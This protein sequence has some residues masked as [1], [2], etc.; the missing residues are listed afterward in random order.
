MVPVDTLANAAA[1]GSVIL[2]VTMAFLAQL[3]AVSPALSWWATALLFNGIGLLLQG[4]LPADA[5]PFA[6]L[7]DGAPFGASALLVYIGS[8]R[9]YAERLEFGPVAIGFAALGLLLLLSTILAL[10]LV[11]ILIGGALFGAAHRFWRDYRGTRDPAV[12]CAVPPIALSGA[13]ALVALVPHQYLPIGQATLGTVMQLANVAAAM[14]LTAVA[15]RRG[16]QSAIETELQR[17]LDSLQLHEREERLRIAI[18]AERTRLLEV[19]EGVPQGLVLYDDEDRLAFCNTSYNRMFPRTRDLNNPGATFEELARASAERG[20]YGKDPAA[21]AATLERR[22]AQHRNPGEPGQ[23]E[24]DDGSIIQVVEHRAHDGSTVC[25]YSDITEFRRREN[26]LTLIVS[27]QPGARSFLDAAAQAL[28]VGL[29]YRWAGIAERLPDGKH[30]RT[31]AAWDSGKPGAPITYG[32]ADTPCEVVYRNDGSLVVA[33]R[34]A[35]RFPTDQILLDMGA[36][37]YQGQVYRDDQGRAVGHLFAIDDKPDQRGPALHPLMGLVAHWVGM[38]SQRLTA[39]RALVKAKEAAEE[40]SRAKTTFLANMSHELRTPLNAI[41]GFSEIM[42]DQ[43]LG[44]LGRPQYQAYAED[45]CQ[46]GS[47]LLSL[48]ND[49]LDLSKAGAGK[50][51]LADEEIDPR[52]LIDSC[53]RL[54]ETRAK[55]G[56][57]QLHSELAPGRLRLFADRRRLKQILLNLLSNAIKFTAA[58]GKVAIRGWVDPAGYMLQV[59]DTGI[60]IAAADIPKIM[61]PFGQ[62]DSPTVALT[63][64]VGLGLPLSKV[65]AELHGGSLNIASTPGAGTTVTLALPAWRVRTAQAF[66]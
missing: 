20:T 30:A 12:G 47:H 18:E 33:D 23:F 56:N 45:I 46:S 40:A 51:D 19:M 43:L 66:G 21:V 7:V 34:L 65:L 55:R 58:G 36:V 6:Q 24:T 16:Q 27:N 9:F 48:I 44:P 5:A 35:E 14:V 57:V 26:A 49:L 31:L 37:A 63:E 32:L 64:G 41:I 61:Q 28:A 25:A 11:A 62:V 53:L 39:E 50:I 52:G 42:R 1:L 59:A 2:A 29:G 3:P 17:A 38:E 15:M 10:P 4:T 22:M 8:R 60:G 13:L 54:V